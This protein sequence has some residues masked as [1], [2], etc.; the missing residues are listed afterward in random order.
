MYSIPSA[1]PFYASAGHFMCGKTH[2][3]VLLIKK[4]GGEGGNGHTKQIP[5][6]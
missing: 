5:K 4:A 6:I 1:F 3:S 2:P